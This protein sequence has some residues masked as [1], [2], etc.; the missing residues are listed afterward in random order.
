M[1][2]TYSVV[3]FTIA[4]FVSSGVAA[5]GQTVVLF[6]IYLATLSVDW[7]LF[8][9]PFLLLSVVYELKCDVCTRLFSLCSA[10]WFL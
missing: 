8:F 7:A 6:P 10:F 3:A 4:L 5:G 9:L 2:G 1:L